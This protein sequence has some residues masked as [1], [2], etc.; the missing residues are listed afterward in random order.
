MRIIFV[1]GPGRSG[2]SFVAARLGEHPAVGTLPGIELKLF[3]E[4]G[5]LLDLHHSL[6]TAYS[7]NRATVAVRQFRTHMESLVLGRFGQKQLGELA[8]AQVWT[9]LR[10]RFLHRL[11]KDAHPRRLA[12][13]DFL[14]AAQA[15]VRDVATTCFAQVLDEPDLDVFLE[16][17]P[18]ALLE[19]TFLERIA[20]GSRYLH[21]MR[22]PRSIAFSLR[23]V[24]WGP[25]RLETCCAWVGSYCEAYLGAQAAA[26][27][28]GLKIE[29]ANIELLAASTNTEASRICQA[30]ELEPLSTLFDG[31]STKTLNAWT[32]SATD[33]DRA[34]LDDR[35]GGWAG[36]FGYALDG[37]GLLSHQADAA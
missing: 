35:L 1:G 14:D 21:V 24:R 3:T 34:L 17:T 7:P 6:V 22:D 8:P 11:M 27:H 23:R 32:E 19:T 31:A 4:K 5:G 28:R 26:A 37:I 25:E 20:P 9:D 13:E 36:H 30:L 29:Q 2:T 16:K 12:S 18:H 15:F 33:A 10:E